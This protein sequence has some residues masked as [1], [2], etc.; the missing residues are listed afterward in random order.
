[1][2]YPYTVS[3]L[4][5]TPNTALSQQINR[6]GRPGMRGAPNDAVGVQ[7]PQANKRVQSK[8]FTNNGFSVMTLGTGTPRHSTVRSRPATLVSLDDIDILVDMGTGT[9]NRLYEEGVDLSQIEHMLI[10]HHHIDHDAEIPMLLVTATVRRSLQSFY[11]PPNT[12]SY[13]R[14]CRTF[15]WRISL[16]SLIRRAVKNST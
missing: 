13:I 15:I 2:E 10:T 11:G 7:R 4:R 8:G 16:M 9:E 1:M 5:G 6:P 12:A 3:C 14:F